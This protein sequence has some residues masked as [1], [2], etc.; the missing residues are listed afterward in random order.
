VAA[1]HI[2]FRRGGVAYA[3]AWK[4]LAERCAAETFVIL[5]VAHTPLKGLFAVTDKDFE[6]PLGAVPCDRGLARDLM[7]RAGLEQGDDELVH[8]SEHSVEFQ[9]V[10]LRHVFGA[11]RPA[12]I[13]PVLCGHI[14][15]ALGDKTNPLDVPAITD[16]VGALREL[17]KEGGDRV[18]VIASVDLSHVGRR[19]NDQVELTPELLTRV[20]AQD[21]ALLKHAER[22]DAAAFFETNYRDKDRRHV[23]GFSAL[24]ALLAAVPARHGRLLHYGQAPERETQSVVSFAAMAFER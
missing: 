18:A 21:R 23:C 7:R 22:M 12:R 14:L 5:G 19:F 2:D 6:T 15:E 9:A 11:S 4:E 24:F 20:E 16:F 17:L 13:V 8:R 10:F 3:H 1:P